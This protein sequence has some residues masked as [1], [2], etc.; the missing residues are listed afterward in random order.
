MGGAWTAA[1]MDAYGVF[2][3]PAG[4]ASLD[5]IQ[6]SASTVR[7]FG[8]DFSSQ[9]TAAAGIPLPGRWGTLGAGVRGFG[10]EYLGE[11]LTQE[12]TFAIGHGV[13]LRRDRQSELAV[14]WTLD[15]YSLD[16]GR[17]VTGIDPGSATAFGISLGGE[18]VVRERTRV[19]LFALNLNNPRIGDLDKEELRRRVSAGVSYGP[20]P[21]VETVLEIVSELG[22]SVQYRG[23]IEFELIEFAWLRAGIRTDPS[24][25]TAGIG[26]RWSGIL[27]DYGFSTGGGVLEDTHHFG[28]GYAQPPRR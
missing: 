27:L 19:G 5:H 18:A 9:N 1:R 20:Y 25:F 10:V 26:L 15:L 3:N 17:S 23:G 12:N 8:Y 4:L 6:A 28:V 24:V 14:G 22:E 7:P 16:F 2:H 11:T 13:H 21:G